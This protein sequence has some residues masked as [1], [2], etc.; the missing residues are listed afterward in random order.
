ECYFQPERPVRPVDHLSGHRAEACN[1]EPYQLAPINGWRLSR[2]T[3]AGRSYL[4][5]WI[6]AEATQCIHGTWQCVRRVTKRQS[7]LQQVELQPHDAGKAVE[8]AANHGLFGWAV[9]AIETQ[10]RSSTTG[11]SSRFGQGY[12]CR[13]R[14]LRATAAIG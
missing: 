3:F 9:H 6:E 13:T 14:R 11:I 4:G 5:H 10:H 8:L 7:P 12:R 2:W 1:A